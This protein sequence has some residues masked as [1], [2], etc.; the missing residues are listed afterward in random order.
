MTVSPKDGNDVS[1]TLTGDGVVIT[2]G[3]FE[4]ANGHEYRT[5][6]KAMDTEKYVSL[7]LELEKCFG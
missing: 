5:A 4:T 7:L 6:Y 1:F 2:D 3:I